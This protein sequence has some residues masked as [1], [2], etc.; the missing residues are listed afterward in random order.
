MKSTFH[1]H[2][3]KTMF[4]KVTSGLQCVVLNGQDLILVPVEFSRLFDKTDRSDSGNSSDL[5]AT[6]Q[7]PPSFFYSCPLTGWVQAAFSTLVFLQMTLKSKCLVLNT[8]STCLTK[9]DIYEWLNRH[10]L[11]CNMFIHL[12][13]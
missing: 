8:R 10:H 2:G 13:K 4:L 3:A 6:N 11:E 5:V 9:S 7:P 1:V 12:F